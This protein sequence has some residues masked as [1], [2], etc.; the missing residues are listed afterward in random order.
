MTDPRK[1]P[2]AGW[3]RALF[4]ACAACTLWLVLE[5]SILLVVLPHW[6]AESHR[7]SAEIRHD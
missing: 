3:R 2:L 7:S 5:N 1:S 4:I 6:W